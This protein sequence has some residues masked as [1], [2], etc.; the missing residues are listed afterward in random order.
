MKKLKLLKRHYKA[1]LKFV[2][3]HKEMTVEDWKKVVWSNETK[4]NFFGPDGKQFCWIKN[5][6][7]NSKLV[8]L[9]VKFGSSSIMIW[10]CMTWEGV[11]GMCLVLGTMNTDQYIDYLE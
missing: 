6:S 3:E 1:H 4:I 5:T 2:N 9:T 11:G 10:G 8:R 7:F